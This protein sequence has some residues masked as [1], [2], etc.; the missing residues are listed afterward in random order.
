MKN[1]KSIIILSVVFGFILVAAAAF[2]G[3]RLLNGP[4]NPIGSILSPGSGGFVLSESKMVEM[5]PAP[6]LPTTQPEVM[7][8]FVKRQDGSIFIQEFSMDFAGGGGGP[9]IAVA[10]PSSGSDTS[11][12]PSNTGPSVEVV[13]TNK[14]LIYSDATQFDSNSDNNSVIE[15]KVKPS[16][17][18]AI[19]SQSIIT[20][21][22]RKVGDR[23]IADVILYQ[24]SGHIRITISSRA[25]L[26]RVF[27]LINSGG[28]H[29]DPL[30]GRP[31]RI[32]LN[33]KTGAI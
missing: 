3:G 5:K 10:A 6:E 19:S 8:S 27:S 17:A 7:G 28:F 14:T 13:I 24:H 20:V 15:Q 31:K 26:R 22:G 2:I 16:T 9:S 18:D 23:V 11:P 30:T 4:G 29:S 1:K 33:C 25:L 12:E 21:W 32:R